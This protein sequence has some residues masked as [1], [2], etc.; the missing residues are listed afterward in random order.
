MPQASGIP[1]YLDWTF[2]AVVIAAL[3]LILSQLPP[4]HVLLKR[5]R[6]DL[7]V[8][9][10]VHVNHKIGNPTVQL[11]LILNNSGGKTIKVRDAVVSINRDGDHVTDLPAQNY[12]QNPNDKSAVLF[13][14]FSLRIK[15]EWAHI[16]NFFNIFSRIDDKTYR[17]AESALKENIFEKKELSEN[18]K[19][20]FEANPSL[21]T[22]FIE[23]FAQKYIW[24]PGEYELRILINAL[25]EEASITRAYRF[26][27]FESD[28]NEL[29]KVKDDYKYGDGIY[30]NS[31]R[32]RGVTVQI[33]EA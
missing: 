29:A 27:I 3:A 15:D 8:Y 13:T 12:L 32:H 20:P 28:S 31:P 6:L 26:T 22:P 23:M 24:Q 30:W 21:V 18:K 16:V 4:V 9:S 17:G 7:E 11:H 19:G 1:F 25:P 33:A 5:A 10:R 2:W 14:P